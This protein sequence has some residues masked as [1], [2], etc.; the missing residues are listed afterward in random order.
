MTYFT[1]YRDNFCWVVRT[2]RQ[3]E[4]RGRWQQRTPAMAAGLADHD[5][6]CFGKPFS[7][8][9]RRMEPDIAAAVV[10]SQ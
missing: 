5:W 6:T 7:G 10:H 3:R 9:L 8:K 4:N 1:L 2:L